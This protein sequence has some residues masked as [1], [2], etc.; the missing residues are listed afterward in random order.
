[1]GSIC[2]VIKDVNDILPYMNI[3][4]EGLHTSL[5]D[6]IS[7]IRIFA[8]KAIGKLAEKL[9]AGNLEKYLNFVDEILDSEKSTSIE[10]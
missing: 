4:V 8:S 10:R 1:M 5:G 6:P 2:Q 9:G 7:D 3:L